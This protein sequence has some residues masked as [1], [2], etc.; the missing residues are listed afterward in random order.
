[1]RLSGLSPRGDAWRI[2]IEQPDSMGGIAQAISL[3]DKA[4]ATSGDYRNYFERDGKR[5]SHSIDPR[6][7]YPVAHDLVS[8]TVVHTS[9][10]MADAWATA[11][12]VMG[13][14][15]SSVGIPLGAIPLIAGVDRLNDMM[16]T[17]TNVIGDLFAT[18]II[19]KSEHE[20]DSNTNK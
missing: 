11:L 20:I 7:G 3:S 13:A 15:Q 18:A 8:V 16:Q 12:I 1:M 17:C 19:A 10:M 4:V 5:Y 14:V 6:T 9:A 2:A